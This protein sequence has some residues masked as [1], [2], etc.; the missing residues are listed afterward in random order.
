MSTTL[1]MEV[2]EAYRVLRENAQSVSSEVIEMM[3]KLALEE[4]DRD[5]NAFSFTGEAQRVNPKQY[6]NETLAVWT[7]GVALSSDGEELCA[8]PLKKGQLYKV[9]VEK[10]EVPF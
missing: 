4:L 9:T 5:Q 2:H 6:A 8:Y 7:D 3:K 1:K 10:V